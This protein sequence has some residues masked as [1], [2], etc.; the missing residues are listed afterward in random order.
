MDLAKIA[1]SM[2]FV[3]LIYTLLLVRFKAEHLSSNNA[4]YSD[5]LLPE[6]SAMRLM[7]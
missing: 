6:L 4:L 3:Q 2:P 7:S 1:R 5:V